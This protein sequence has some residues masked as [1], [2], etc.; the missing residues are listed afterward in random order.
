MNYFIEGI[1]KYAQFHGRA[2][3]AEY[4]NFVLFSIILT[5]AIA[6]LEA[7]AGMTPD[8]SRGGVISMLF[9]IFILIP[10]LAVGVRRLHDTNT[11][12]WFTFIALIPIIGILVLIFKLAQKGDTGANQ[13]GADPKGVTHA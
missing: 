1:K 4:W 13:Y 8:F 10:S 7:S 11:S 5:L 2:R 12:G 6:L 9:N 3:R